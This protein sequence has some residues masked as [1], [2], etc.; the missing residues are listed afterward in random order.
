MPHGKH[1][2]TLEQQE[3]EGQTWQLETFQL[4]ALSNAHKSADQ[5]KGSM[6]ICYYY[7]HLVFVVRNLS[8]HYQK[9][10]S[11]FETEP[12]A[13]KRRLWTSHLQKKQ[14][15]TQW[16][17]HYYRSKAQRTTFLQMLSNYWEISI[18]KFDYQKP[19]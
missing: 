4:K 15:G 10:I 7:T 16:Q 18:P 8:A 12:R 3:L 17:C 1:G 11:P 14:N 2:R 19:A 9:T 13:H 6:R 5:Q